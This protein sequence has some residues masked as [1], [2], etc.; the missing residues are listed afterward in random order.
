MAS[1][2]P[3]SERS[4]PAPAAAGSM[5]AFF[6]QAPMLRVRDPL[7]AFLGAVDGG[8]IEYRYADAV[9]LAGHSCPTVAVAWLMT[10]K[11]L[12]ALYDGELPER[13]GVDVHMRDGREDGVTGV[14]ASV[15]T[16]LTGAT[17]ETGF[18]GIGPLHRFSRRNLLHYGERIEGTLALRR[19]DSGQAVQVESDASVVPWSD[20]MRLLMPKAV[21]ETATPDELERFGRLWQQRVR[22][23]LVEHADD[24]RLIQV[25]EWRPAQ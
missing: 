7:A 13:G 8:V 6:E 18:A 17:V 16:L 24:P 9:R 12:R 10:I 20:E 3:T 15:A 22:A 14:V 5:P 2:E 25:R 19:R 11:G 4:N 1:P 23:M 21:T